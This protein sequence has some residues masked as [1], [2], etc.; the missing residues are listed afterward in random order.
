MADHWLKIVKQ[1]AEETAPS[2]ARDIARNALEDAGEGYSS[3]N[4]RPE[5][6]PIYAA[7]AKRRADHK[8]AKLTGAA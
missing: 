5:Y 1:I 3:P 8:A 7:E 6:A 2:W 4:D